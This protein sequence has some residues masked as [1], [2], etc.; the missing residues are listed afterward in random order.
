[1][2]HAQ[3]QLLACQH[4]H[5]LQTV[6]QHKHTLQILWKKKVLNVLRLVAILYAVSVVN[7]CQVRDNLS[8][9]DSVMPSISAHIAV[10]V[11]S[12]QLQAS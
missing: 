8:H 4:K 6:G 2:S 9:L 1:M 12:T 7:V 5:M 10:G 3:T 11:L